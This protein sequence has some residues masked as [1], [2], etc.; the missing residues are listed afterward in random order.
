MS[1]ENESPMAS[2]HRFAELFMKR[3]LSHAERQVLEAFVQDK[4]QT[5]AQA[6]QRSIDQVREQTVRLI[7]AD[8]LRTNAVI[9]QFRTSENILK[10]TPQT[11]EEL[12]KQ[13][14]TALEEPP[15]PSIL[16]VDDADFKEL[17]MDLIRQEV[18]NAME[19]QM[20]SLIQQVESTL[21]RLD[22]QGVVAAGN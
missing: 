7:E 1:K 3:P 12:I 13:L 14:L 17:L 16:T 11:R 20:K 22:E 2:I 19:E 5:F 4:P 18:K 6:A 21:A 15:Q 9:D 10:H 8:E